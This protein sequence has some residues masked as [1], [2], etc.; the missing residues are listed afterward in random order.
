[1]LVRIKNAVITHQSTTINSL[2]TIIIIYSNTVITIRIHNT[3]H[4]IF[5]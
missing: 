2:R 5:I 1:M 3:V 4:L